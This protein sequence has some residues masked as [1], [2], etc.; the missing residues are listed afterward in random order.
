MPS[1]W[2]IGKYKAI[3]EV[4]GR[5]DSTR[6]NFAGDSYNADSV[7]IDSALGLVNAQPRSNKEFLAEKDWLYKY[8]SSYKA[9]KFSEVYSP[10]K[11]DHPYP[12]PYPLD[13]TKVERGKV[14]FAQNC[15]TCHWSQAVGETG[16]PQPVP[17]A[18]IRTGTVVPVEEVGTDDERIKSWNKEA[19]I[20]ANEEVESF[21]IHR[22]GLVEATPTGYVAAFLDGIW[23]RAPYL[24]N[25]SVPTL[26]DLLNPVAQ[27]PK[28]FYRGYDVYDPING[29]FVSTPAQAA[30]LTPIWKLKP[31][32][33]LWGEVTAAGTPY[34]VNWRSNGNKGHEFGVNLP[35]A[36]KDALIEFLK[37]L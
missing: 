23:L 17:A 7:I 35:Q 21:D 15:A 30:Q 4:T 34:D 29:G 28:V 18:S 12:F 26:R 19:A 9:P 32:E 25:G 22:K 10:K 31:D 37:T 24:H 27:R 20:R 36:D 14:V 11:P 6:L 2:N 1:I 13:E 3:E 16:V 8:I 5:K 33:D